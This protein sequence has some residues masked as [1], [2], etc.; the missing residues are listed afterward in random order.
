M[1][2]RTLDGSGPACQGEGWGHHVLMVSPRPSSVVV[3]AVVA[4]LAADLPD[5]AGLGDLHQRPVSWTDE[6]APRVRLAEVAHR[7]EVDEVRGAVRPEQHL[8]G[9][10]DALDHLGE[11]LIGGDV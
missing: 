10:V 4:T 8:D 2:G 3:V 9:P 5:H 7:T 6:P 11:C 1:A